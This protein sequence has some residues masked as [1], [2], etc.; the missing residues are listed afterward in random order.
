MGVAGGGLTASRRSLVALSSREAMV[1]LAD[2]SRSEYCHQQPG[3]SI[4]PDPAPGQI[5]R[6]AGRSHAG[7]PPAHLEGTP[8]NPLGTHA[9]TLGHKA[10]T[11]DPSDRGHTLEGVENRPRH[12]VGA[13]AKGAEGS[14]HAKESC[15]TWESGR[16][17]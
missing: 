16:G 11:R 1:I 5:A 8:L 14:I 10:P 4:R 2:G 9:G 7:A 17:T 3:S 15:G 6:Q 12:L 13:S